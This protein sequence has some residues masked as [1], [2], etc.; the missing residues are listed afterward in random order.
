MQNKVIA[1]TVKTETIQTSMHCSKARVTG[2]IIFNE[3]SSKR[4]IPHLLEW[5]GVA[6][7][8]LST[9]LLFTSCKKEELGV[10]CQMNPTTNASTGFQ[11]RGD[12]L[13]C[14]S[15]VCVQ[16]RATQSSSQEAQVTEG[17]NASTTTA[18]GQ[19]KSLGKCSEACTEDVGASKTG[20]NCEGD[21]VCRYGKA[22]SPYK[23]CKFWQCSTDLDSASV[24]NDPLTEEC[25]GVMADDCPIF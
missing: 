2:A 19:V 12:A 5:I 6:S 23:C 25:A 9:S 14:D 7:L 24:N 21:Y 17:E 8:L 13:E 16:N 10:I 1:Q 15:R 22:V 18:T 20:E 4:R 3:R 11:I